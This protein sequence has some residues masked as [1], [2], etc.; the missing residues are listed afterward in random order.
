MLPPHQLV[1]IQKF[2]HISFE[3]AYDRVNWGFLLEVLKHRG[4][5]AR[6]ITWIHNLLVSGKSCINLNGE[7]GS[8]FHCKRGL[9]QGDPLSP[10]LFNIVA[11]VLNKILLNACRAD[12]LQ[13]LGNFPTIGNILNLHF[14]DD[15]LLFIKAD[16]KMIHT[17]KWLLLCFENLSGLKINFDK[18]EMVPL[19]ISAST[20]QELAGIVG[21]KLVSLPITYLGVPLHWKNLQER[22]CLVPHSPPRFH[23]MSFQFQ[24]FI[25]L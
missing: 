2:H 20:G 5:G 21:C 10:F 15:T 9:R 23:P 14:A 13:G 7:L 8:Y 17:L 11:D 3:K 12:L 19:N 25:L 6:F 1:Q 4:F 24:Q 16:R 18:S 22:D